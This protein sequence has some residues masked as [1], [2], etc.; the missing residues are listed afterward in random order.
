[1]RRSKKHNKLPPDDK[2]VIAY[3][4]FQCDVKKRKGHFTKE[5]NA[6]VSLSLLRRRAETGDVHLQQADALFFVAGRDL[7]FHVGTH[8]LDIR[9]ANN[10]GSHHRGY[11]SKR[12]VSA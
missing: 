10:R 2:N 4:F 9:D 7:S 1:M 11:G 5:K 12:N 8:S 3:T 6:A